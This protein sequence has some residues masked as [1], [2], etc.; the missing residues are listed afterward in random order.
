[1][2]LFLKFWITFIY[3]IPIKLQDHTLPKKKLQ[4][5]SKKKNFRYEIF[6]FPTCMQILNIYFSQLAYKWLGMTF[7]KENK[8]NYK[9]N[10]SFIVRILLH[11]L[12]I[13]PF[14]LK[15]HSFGLFFKFLTQKMTISNILIDLSYHLMI[16]KKLQSKLVLKK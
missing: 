15:S 16:Q 3:M 13:G 2:F 6:F 4:D 5:H 7:L 12:R 9:F 14:I 1:M 10:C 11:I 8:K